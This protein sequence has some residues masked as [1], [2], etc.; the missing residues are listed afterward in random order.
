[1]ITPESMIDEICKTK[2]Q[3]NSSADFL[4]SI[5]L[6]NSKEYLKIKKSGKL[7]NEADMCLSECKLLFEEV[8]NTI[9]IDFFKQLK[10]EEIIKQ[11]CREAGECKTPENARV[12]KRKTCKKEQPQTK[13]SDQDDM[14]SLLHSL[15][16]KTEQGL[17]Q[18]EKRK[19]K[20]AV[21]YKT[22][23]IVLIKSD[24]THKFKLQ[25]RKCKDSVACQNLIIAI[26]KSMPFVPPKKIVIAMG[27]QQKNGKK[28]KKEQ[29]NL[30]S[31]EERAEIA[32]KREE[33]R[34]REQEEA[35]KKRL[36]KEEN[37]KIAAQKKEEKERLLREKK[38]FE[39]RKRREEF[40]KQQ[41]L[42]RQLPQIGYKDFVIKRSTF[43]CMHN[44]HHTEN[45]VAAVTI[46][47]N[48]LN[49]GEL[50]LEKVSAGYCRECNS[51]FILESTYDNLKFKGML[52]CRVSDEKTYL[53]GKTIN[54]ML[55]AQESIL[56]QYGYTVNQQDDLSE[57]TRRKIL[58][59]LIDNKI[60][61]KSDII[62]YLD[63]F[64]SQRPQ[65]KFHV[66]VSRWE[67]DREF[68]CNYRLGEFTQYG[69]NGI[70]RV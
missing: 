24:K 4:I 68:V 59:V 66:A 29:S 36:K 19:I 45:V 64:I 28:K 57:R 42:L 3:I 52:L 22:D 17:L 35:D 67:A 32:K 33:R 34:K 18:W 65:A 31:E 25:D 1:M 44:N 41:E 13:K 48:N 43:K 54:G 53:K 47:P 50:R 15:K 51:F 5:F 23:G 12:S 11:Y 55:L 16:E 49:S 58:A 7:S 56:M 2:Y 37:A 10:Y 62:S 9:S 30:L 63:F 8:D 26:E 60:L 70:Y 40:E 39:E 46:V 6:N 21:E 38:E 14:P 61:S 20:D 27:S 69:I